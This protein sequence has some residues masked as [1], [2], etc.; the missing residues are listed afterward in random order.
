MALQQHQFCSGFHD[1]KEKILK[2][3]QNDPRIRAVLL[4][5]SRANPNVKPDPYQDYDIMWIVEDLPSFLDDRSWLS[6]F[7]KPFLQQFPDDTAIGI[8][9]PKLK[10]KVSYTILTIFEDGKR[11]DLTLF[12]KEKFDTHFE[13]DSLTKVWLD[14]DEL[15]ADIADSSDQDYHIPKPDQQQFDEVSN[16]FWWTITYAA[17]GLR[18]NELI[19]AKDMLETVVR[20]IFYRMFSWNIAYENQFSVNIGKSGKF[21]RNYLDPALHEKI[22]N[23]YSGADPENNWKALFLMADIFKHE[24]LKLAKRLDFSVNRQEA[25]NSLTILQQFYRN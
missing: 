3:A 23:T 2:I 6:V 21:A 19:Y 16:E 5:G 8:A 22:L 17:K 10:E 4:N 9:A 12:P 15:F 11:L 18:R 7:G 13:Q 14:K 25:E 20:P 1:M 24:Q